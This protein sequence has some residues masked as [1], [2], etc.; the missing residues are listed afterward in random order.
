MGIVATLRSSIKKHP[1]AWFLISLSFV[2]TLLRLPSLFEPY[3]YG[4]EGIYQVVGHAIHD[5]A[6]LYQDI[7]DNKPPLLYFIY[8]AFNGELFFVKLLSLLVGLISVILFFFVGK[9]LFKGAPLYSATLIFAV[10]FATPIIEGNIANAE[11]F[12]MLPALGSLYFLLSYIQNKQIRFLILSGILISISS[13]LKI[14]GIFDFFAFFTILL[15]INWDAIFKGTK[16]VARN[17]RPL[18]IYGLS[19][20]IIPFITVLIFYAQGSFTPFYNAVLG[21]NIGYVGFENTFIFPMGI[22][23]VKTLLLLGIVLY[24]FLKRNVFSLST[25]IVY[26]WLVFSI[27]NAF[28]SQ[29]AY[30]HYVLVLLP[31]FCLLIAH[32]MTYKK[33]RVLDALIMV[34]IIAAVTMHFSIYKYSYPY[35]KNYLEFIIG[36]SDVTAYQLFFDRNT[37]RDYEIANFIKANAEEGERIFLWSDSAQIYALSNTQP[38]SK[39]VVSYHVTFYKDGVEKVKE[40]MEAYKPRF[41]IQTSDHPEIKSFLS[42]Y[43]LRYRIQGVTIYEREI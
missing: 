41:I 30:I 7:W 5:G 14:V 3:W 38:I 37:P 17:T 20:L 22:L 19:F 11:N 43:D 35:Y 2:F 29:R 42:S 8:A 36:K 26:V 40:G 28:F 31:A 34:G 23:I 4:D 32:M 16:L 15:F 12:M 13:L 1:T 6:L 25:L 27:Y 21:D 24:L 18:A 33:T 10:L 39:Y 9:K